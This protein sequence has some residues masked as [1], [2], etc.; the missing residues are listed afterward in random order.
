MMA[1]QGLTLMSVVFISARKII[2]EVLHSPYK[3][4]RI[5]LLFLYR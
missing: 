4:F 3:V 2:L 5:T 1:A